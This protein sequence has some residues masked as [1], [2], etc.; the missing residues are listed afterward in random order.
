MYIINRIGQK[1]GDLKVIGPAAYSGEQ[2]WCPCQCWCGNTRGVEEKR[3]VSGKITMCVPCE[4]RRKMEENPFMNQGEEI[5][6]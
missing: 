6:G 3:L 1:F 5:R 2:A 4:V